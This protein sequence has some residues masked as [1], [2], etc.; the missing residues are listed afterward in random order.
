MKLARLQSAFSDGKKGVS[1]KESRL[2]T[3][4]KLMHEYSDMGQMLNAIKV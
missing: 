1:A 2:S 4:M 3:K